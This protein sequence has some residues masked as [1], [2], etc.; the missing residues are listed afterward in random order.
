MPTDDLAITSLLSSHD[1]QSK[2][3]MPNLRTLNVASNYLTAAS[4]KNF[5]DSLSPA[6]ETLNLSHNPIGSEAILILP[7][8]A[9]KFPNLRSI[10]LDNCDIGVGEVQTGRLTRNAGEEN[11]EGT[12][13]V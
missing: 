9:S 3:I 5:V 8:A 13:V 1:G 4:F 12:W 6:L 10:C 11:S 7:N 2:P